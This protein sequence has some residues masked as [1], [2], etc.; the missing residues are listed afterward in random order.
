MKFIYRLFYREEGSDD[1]HEARALD[2]TSKRSM[3]KLIKRLSKK[4]TGLTF[5]YRV[6]DPTP[7]HKTDD[8]VHN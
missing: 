4:F 3:L 2:Q 1:R 8:E 5:G 6:I 7:D